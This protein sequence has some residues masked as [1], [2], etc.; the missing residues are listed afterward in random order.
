MIDIKEINNNFVVSRA[1]WASLPGFP[2][3]RPCEFVH[4]HQRQVFSS[5]D[6]EM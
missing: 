6:Q 5:Y 1:V 4:E 3:V 2:V